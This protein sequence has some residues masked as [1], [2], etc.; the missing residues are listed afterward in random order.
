MNPLCMYIDKNQVFCHRNE[1]SSWY[2]GLYTSSLELAPVNSDTSAFPLAPGN[3]YSIISYDDMNGFIFLMNEITQSLNSCGWI[4]SLNI[5]IFSH[6][7]VSTN[8]KMSFIFMTKYYSIV[9]MTCFLYPLI[10]W[11]ACK[12]FPFFDDYKQYCSECRVQMSLWYPD[13]YS[14]DIYPA[15]RFAGSYGNSIFNFWGTSMLFA[16]ITVLI[17]IPTSSV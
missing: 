2:N 10:K 11:W 3:Q 12:F 17:Y 13:S 8:D 5:I 1:K 15:M 14:L 4:I 6:M 7:T 16:V 9:Y